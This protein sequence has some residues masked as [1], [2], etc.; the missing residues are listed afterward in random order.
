MKKNFVVY[1]NLD[2]EDE[3]RMYEYL[4]NRDKNFTIKRLLLNEIDGTNSK[5]QKEKVVNDFEELFNE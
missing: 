4:K 5:P 1:L 2:N 3:K